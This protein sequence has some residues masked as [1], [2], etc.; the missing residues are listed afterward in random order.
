MT[1]L[2]NRAG[3]KPAGK[4][5]PVKSTGKCL[6]NLE[7]GIWNNICWST[8]S[9]SPDIQKRFCTDCRHG[10]RVSLSRPG[11]TY[12]IATDGLEDQHKVPFADWICTESAIRH[13]TR[14][15]LY[16]SMEG[17]AW[18]PGAPKI[19]E[20]SLVKDETRHLIDLI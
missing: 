3:H 19:Q 16:V 1:I 20:K 15:V 11:W 7:K 4:K 10:Y 5:R 18:V 14:K 17:V 6:C 8:R 9:S 13:T 2:V 12:A